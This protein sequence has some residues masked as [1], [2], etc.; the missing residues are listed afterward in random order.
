MKK[1][2]NEAAYHKK[3]DSGETIPS[4]KNKPDINSDKRYIIINF[5]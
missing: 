3:V 5:R 1:I 4:F 2:L